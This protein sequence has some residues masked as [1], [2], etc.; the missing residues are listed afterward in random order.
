MVAVAIII[1]SGQTLATSDAEP[2]ELR[3][4]MQDMGKSM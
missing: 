4:I 2:M 3:K 1:I